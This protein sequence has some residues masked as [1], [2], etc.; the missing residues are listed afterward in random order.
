[1]K[2]I[3]I[4]LIVMAFFAVIGRM[5]FLQQESTP[6]PAP[7][8]E[9]KG[10]VQS[11]TV[12]VTPLSAEVSL[13][14]GTATTTWNV[15]A[16]TSDAYDGSHVKTSANGRAIIT[17]ESDIISSLD[18]NS[19]VTISLSPDKKRSQIV[20][21]AGK[22]WSKVGR[23]LEQDEQFEVYTPTMVA[24]VRGTS[25]GV[26]LNPKRSLIVAEGTVW[27]SRR[28]AQTGERVASSTIAVSAGNTV[29]DNGIDF[30]VRPILPDDRD[31]WYTFNTREV[32]APVYNNIPGSVSENN[33]SSSPDVE[34]PVS[35]P[36]VTVSLPEV[37]SVSPS[38]FDPQAVSNVRIIGKNLNGV[39][40][41]SLNKKSAEF[42]ITPVGVI[43]IRTTEFRDGD[44]SYDLAVIS[45]LKTITLPN[46]FTVQA[47]QS[48][49]GTIVQ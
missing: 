37:S 6:A 31:E 14:S 12:A 34:T 49:R 19:E 36:V 3:L 27:I 25:F 26:S 21:V 41:V 46:A 29:E 33:T 24:A 9:N 16:S 23:A 32:D 7:V 18:N 13:L 11:A 39:T 4:L 30:L 2:R 22:I 1:M 42:S 44:G 8:S 40:Q 35:V 45:P 5:V 47:V 28:D 17:R 43:V 10:E 48:P 15:I 38:S 20:I